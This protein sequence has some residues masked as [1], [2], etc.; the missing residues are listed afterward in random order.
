M[1]A[2]GPELFAALASDKRLKILD[3]LKDPEAHFPPQREG[4]LV[5]DGVCDVLIAEKLGVAHPTAT[6]HLQALGRAG[7]VTSKRVGQW[8]FYKR[9]EPAIRNL[10]RAIRSEL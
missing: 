2:L 7:L 6:T 4:D 3:W 1:A 9:D 8:T 5:K 10:A